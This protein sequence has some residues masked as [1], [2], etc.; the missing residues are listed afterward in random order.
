[1]EA[2]PPEAP[3]AVEEIEA[4]AVAF[5]IPAAPP[6]AEEIEAPAV[7]FEI[8][9]A[10]PEAEEE[11]AAPPAEE[12]I[13]LPPAV[14]EIEPPPF[15]ISEEPPAQVIEEEPSEPGPKV[16]DLDAQEVEAGYFVPGLADLGLGAP[17]P[18][19][20]LEEETT[21]IEAPPAEPRDEFTEDHEKALAWHDAQ[22]LP[23]PPRGIKN[24]AQYYWDMAEDALKLGE[25]EEAWAGFHNVLELYARGGDPA[26]S[27][28]S[29][30]RLG[31]TY[32]RMPVGAIAK[33][34]PLPFKSFVW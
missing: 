29:L 18:E 25:W 31:I 19:A 26:G 3:S 21:A 13:P 32:R 16:L 12:E 30:W 1:V 10:P 4:P 33:A 7:P 27:A 20:P 28:R 17:G 6:E 22:G 23:H 8:P 24:E 5:E 34:P 11:V 9:A 2:A 14:S 15:E